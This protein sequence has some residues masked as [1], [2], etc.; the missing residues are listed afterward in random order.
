MEQLVECIQVSS[1]I[2]EMYDRELKESLMMLPVDLERMI[3]IIRGLCESLK[4]MGIQLQGQIESIPLE[5]RISA[6]WTNTAQTGKCGHE[7]R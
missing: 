6:A 7:E 2:Q 4:I 1:C 3:P 5:E